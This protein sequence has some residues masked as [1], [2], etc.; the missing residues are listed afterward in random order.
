M[1]SLSTCEFI[2]DDAP[3][4]LTC[5]EG[6]LIAHFAQP[7]RTA[8]WAVINGGLRTTRAVAWHQ[9]HASD[10]RPPVNAVTWLRDRMAAR[11]VSDAV[12]LMTSRAVETY[13]EAQTSYGAWEARCVTTVGLG[14]ALRVG[15][16]PGVQGRIGT[17]NTLLH[18]SQPVTDSALL[19]ALALVTEARTVAVVESGVLSR[20]SG[21]PASG[22]GT[23]C[24]VVCAPVAKKPTPYVGKHTVAGHVL[25]DAVLRATRQG[26][27]RCLKDYA[28]RN[29]E[30][31]P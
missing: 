11:G 10:L 3:W 5:A 14:N 29:T 21:Q 31:T 2:R 26:I 24:I 15:D 22:T 1:S 18:L 17:I 30:Q 27:E 19:E 20:M 13:A 4:Q 28:A 12:G 23:D 7:Q 6:W 9:V 25:G 8:S 16:A